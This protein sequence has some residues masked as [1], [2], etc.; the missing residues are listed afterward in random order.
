MIRTPDGVID[1]TA[2]QKLAAEHLKLDS[3]IVTDEI[4]M[5]VGLL[6]TVTEEL[7]SH[8]ERLEKMRVTMVY[9]NNI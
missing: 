9:Q 6:A 1:V 7:E 3:V 5:A 8:I 4:K 2:I